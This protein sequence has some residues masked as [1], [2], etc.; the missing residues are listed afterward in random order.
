MSREEEITG[1]F[2]GEVRFLSTENVTAKLVYD[3]GSEM[4]AVCSEKIVKDAW[5]VEI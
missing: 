3:D 1:E 4:P 5:V 2:G